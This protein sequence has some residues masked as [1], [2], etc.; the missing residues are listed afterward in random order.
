MGNKPSY[1]ADKL[2]TSLQMAVIR[3]GLI[4]NK[5]MAANYNLKDEIATLLRN[6]QEE[7]AM[8]KVEGFINTE[9]YISALEIVSMFCIQ[10]NERIRQI[11]ESKTCPAELR[12]AIDTLIWSAS[13]SECEEMIKIRKQFAGKYGI[14]Y[15]EKANIDAD[16]MVNHAVLNK[17]VSSIPSENEKM[18]KI[19]EIASE[20]R[21]DF[22]PGSEVKKYMQTIVNP[23]KFNQQNLGNFE[24]SCPTRMTTRVVESEEEKNAASNLRQDLYP[25]DTVDKKA[26]D[27]S[28]ENEKPKIQYPDPDIEDLHEEETKTPSPTNSPKDDPKMQPGQRN[29]L[30]DIEERFNKLK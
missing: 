16:G 26:E 10:C 28:G 24:A 9:N 11:S 6:G 17:L 14:E 1:N 20:K 25:K 4:K 22:V 5:R 19:I 30:D 21:V 13:R 3:I 8:I 29:E 7:M 18:M 2:K 27:A 15:C 12:S 23:M